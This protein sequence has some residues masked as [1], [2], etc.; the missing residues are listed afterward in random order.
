M[1][2]G[3]FTRPEVDQSTRPLV[4]VDRFPLPA[5]TGGRQRMWNFLL[6]IDLLGPADLVVLEP[7][8]ESEHELLTSELPR[9]TVS[10]LPIDRAR[11]PRVLQPLWLLRRNQPFASSRLDLDRTAQSLR[12]LASGRQL[13]VAIQHTAAMV[14]QRA[15]TAD[16]RLVVDLWDVEDVRLARL[17]ES[18]DR[19]QRRRF[20]R[21]MWDDLRNR[22]D[23][24]AWRR[25]HVDL[26]ARADALCVCSEVDRRAMPAS[27]HIWVIPNG[28]D[29]GETPD[30]QEPDGPPV[31]LYHGQLTYP[32][33]VD[34]AHILV[35]QVLPLLEAEVPG[36]QVRLV[37]R[38]DDRVLELHSPPAVTVTGFVDQIEP[39]LDRARLLIVP[40]RVGGGTR[41]KILEAFARRLPVVSTS[42]GAEGLDVEHGQ[43]LLIADEPADMAACAL[44]LLH[45][46]AERIHLTD[47]AEKLVRSRYDWKAIQ[48]DLADRLRGLIEDP[49]TRPRDVSADA[50]LPDQAEDSS[51]YQAG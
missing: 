2:A 49:A 51:S 20:P 22:S 18:E 14:A 35:E 33:N 50:L 39:E 15:R 6:A 38:A 42:V 26:V 25:F 23:I 32:P 29:V 46:D 11:T 31:V 34:A 10:Y 37:G 16:T 7:R 19:S 43:H 30:R 27:D 48:C 41:L 47:E 5:V 13:I 45:D 36:L 1:N 9:W 21:W 4:I 8:P 44:R 12:E 24:R 3:Q 40:L 17:L 28:A